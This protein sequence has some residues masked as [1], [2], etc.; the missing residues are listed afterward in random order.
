MTDCLFCRIAQGEIP[1]TF[2]YQD[3]RC[4]VFDD[5]HP[6]APVHVLIVP[7]EHVESVETL[8]PDQA[9]LAG[10]LVLAAQAAAEAKGI[11]SR[12]YRLIA[13]VG[14]EAGQIIPHLHW[15]LLGGKHLGPKIV[16]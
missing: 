3:D 8:R 1:T 2:V 13:N 15:H 4:V 11:A 7:R 12:G 14:A 9:D 16:E 5:I 6:K 10:H